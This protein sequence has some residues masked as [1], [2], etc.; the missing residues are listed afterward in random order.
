MSPSAVIFGPM[1]AILAESILLEFS[2]R[3]LGRTI[4]GYIL[5]SVLAMSWILF[6]K[7][8][9]YIIF[10]GYNIVEVYEG[11]MEYAQK[12]FN[13]HFDAVWAPVILLLIVYSILGIIS[14]IV[15][16]K[17]G[18]KLALQPIE[19]E[20]SMA[21]V[22]ESG[23]GKDKNHGF[24]YS[25]SWLALDFVFIIGSLILVNIIPF[26]YWAI[27]VIGICAIWAFR[28][29]RALRQLIRPK[30]WIF[31]VL[32]T[33][34]TAFVFTKI[35]STSNSIYD[36]ILIGVE[37]NLRAI[38]LIMGF[39]VLGTE[40]YNPKIRNYFL[41][42]NFKQ[43]PLAVELSVES[44][45]LMIAQIPDLKS[46]IK[47]PVSVMHQVI[48][49]AEFR[50]EEMKN[51][52]KHK[53]EVFILSGSMNQGKTKQIKKIIEKLKSHKIEVEGIYS[54]KI[55]EDTNI[56]GYDIINV[57]TNKRSP[58]LRLSGSDSMGRIGKYYILPEGHEDG[59]NALKQAGESNTNIIIIDEVGR[60][61]LQG[62]GWAE[63]FGKLLNLP[64]K[65]ILMS[66][67][68]EFVQDVIDHWD[69]DPRAIYK[70]SDSSSDNFPALFV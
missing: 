40:L 35:Q 33:M 39:S 29:K 31:F 2:V 3:I 15:G 34:I 66:V 51:S 49:Q 9:N 44:L 50:L 21:S 52:Q 53:S 69:L 30:F 14:A 46:I 38:I 41:N 12:Q 56:T 65:N 5:G 37:M 64:R 59:L 28:Y 32:I 67:R 36:G 24:G 18:R 6:Q 62:L 22:N 48:S 70:V 43:L 54:P 13:W 68:Q 20:N 10:Y 60:L 27:M 1:V 55:M 42:S 8:A 57:S 4:A 16:V 19:P 45:P 63:E 25:I 61:E 26:L 47:N 58:F 17:T 23:S 7:I 11:L